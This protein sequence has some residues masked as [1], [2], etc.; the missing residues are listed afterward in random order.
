MEYAFNFGMSIVET[1]FVI[2]VRSRIV[3]E[4]NNFSVSLILPL[5]YISFNVFK[6]GKI[7]LNKI[8]SFEIVENNKFE[9]MLIACDSFP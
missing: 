8:F 7:I 9:I 6:L 2:S 5:L 4:I 3:V 1:N